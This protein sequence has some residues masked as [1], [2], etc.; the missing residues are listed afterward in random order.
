MSQS[1]TWL[2]WK[3][4]YTS[5]LYLPLPHTR[6]HNNA[7]SL[8]HINSKHMFAL[9]RKCFRNEYF[10]IIQYTVYNAFETHSFLIALVL[11]QITCILLINEKLI[12]GNI[13]KVESECLRAG[14]GLVWSTYILM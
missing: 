12:I 8:T 4:I 14:W 7:V 13:L 10:A 1:V 2:S 5:V 9:Y 6:Y 11:F 3:Q